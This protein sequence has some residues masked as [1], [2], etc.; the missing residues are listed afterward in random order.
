MGSLVVIAPV[1]TSPT[2]TYR[3]LRTLAVCLLVLVQMVLTQDC[4]SSECS[5][6]LKS[7]DD[8]ESCG[9]CNL[10]FGSN[11]GPC[12]QCKWCDGGADG[13]K[14]KCNQGKGSSVCKKC[15]AQCQ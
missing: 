6:C 7:C 2:T 13:C 14:K 5:S 4:K 12:S 3:M 8:C 1:N 11:L 10:C 9:L 15:L